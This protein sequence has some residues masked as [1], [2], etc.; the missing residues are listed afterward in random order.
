MAS[1]V[2]LSAGAAGNPE[3]P[4]ATTATGQAPTYYPG[5]PSLADAQRVTLSIGEEARGLNFSLVAA[6]LAQISGTVLVSRGGSPTNAMVTLRSLTGAPVPPRVRGRTSALVV[7][8]AFT[9]SDVSPG[10]YVLEVRTFGQQDGEDPEF[11]N[12]SIV[13]SG[14]DIANLVV[15]TRKGATLAGLL[16][17]T[18][19][20]PRERRPVWISAISID[21]AAVPPGGAPSRALVHDNGAFELRGLSGPALIRIANAPPEWV[22]KAVRLGGVDITDTPYDFSASDTLPALEIEVTNVTTQIAGQVTDGR[23]TALKEYAVLVF[24]DDQTRWGPHTRYVQVGR[25]DQRGF[26]QIRGLPAGEYLTVAL[27]AS[28]YRRGWDPEL[29]TGLKSRAVSFAIRDGETRQL[30]LK[31]TR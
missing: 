13:V 31:L 7:G 5:T 10:E 25:P 29:L 27:E 9:M 16:R 17:A 21:S 18:F 3:R 1:S 30:S 20:V 12:V 15:T 23:G 2:P 8:G 4:E 24:S 19:P 6:K 11:A 22:L 14:S 28:E 26:F